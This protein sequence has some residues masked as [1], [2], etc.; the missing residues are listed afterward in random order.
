MQKTGTIKT[1]TEIPDKLMTLDQSRILLRN[2][3]GPSWRTVSIKEFYQAVE[4]VALEILS[5][6]IREND[7][8][9]IYSDNCCQ[10]II[11]DFAI[12][13]CGAITVP[14]YPT[15]PSDQIQFILQN[16]GVRGIFLSHQKE[17][18]K[19]RSLQS[20]LPKLVWIVA[21]EEM[22]SLPDHCWNMEQ[23]MEEGR[24]RRSELYEELQR[25]KS[26]IQPDHIASIIYTSGTT[27]IPKGVMLS[28]GNFI[29]NIEATVDL[30]KFGSQDVGLSFLPL[31][32]VFERYA[33]YKYLYHGASIA[34]SSVDRILKHCAEV[35]PTVTA[36][37]PRIFEI[38]QEKILSRLHSSS[39][40]KKTLFRWGMAIGRKRGDILLSG[41][42]P[43]WLLQMLFFLAKNIVFR[44]LHKNLGKRFRFFISGGGPLL[45]EIG[46][47]FY[48]MGVTICEGYGLT[49]TS[50]VVAVN[51]PQDVRFGTVGKI[52]EGVEVKIAE[53]GEILVQGPNVMKGYYKNEIATRETF[54]D[55][56]LCTGDTGELTDGYLIIKERKKDIIVT[57]SG[58]NIS[59][60]RIENFL[61]RSSFINNAVV[62]GDAMD[63]IS[64]LIVPNFEVL[65]EKTDHL[66]I[67]A[68]KESDLI[69]NEKIIDLYRKE[70][71]AS[72][73]SL[74][75]YE[76]VRKFALM[77]KEFTIESGEMTP[78]MK[79]KRR[80]VFDRYHDLIES[81]YPKTR[82][83]QERNP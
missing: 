39:A 24:Q 44:Q 51:T 76:K 65:K 2:C 64:A 55:G 35:H 8:V 17:F 27:G 7:R 34:F 48:A 13:M 45:P 41:K 31:S 73:R 61:K 68:L 5:L 67:S 71:F 33:D 14:V 4:D 37:V 82:D 46:K 56:W 32:H 19:I 69:K 40:V 75:S 62:F 72:T 42:K 21:F 29:S 22:E 9:A 74:A 10:W 54:R 80:V 12:L 52:V 78:T 50:P 1:L 57:S 60:Q 36:S 18:R 58:K 81:M 47:F 79:I 28:Q 59:P 25:R 11:A 43:S 53:D 83:R 16:S 66:D 3:E 49:E 20:S 77:D 70:I 23:F 26:S 63:Y 15:L 30:V 6:G 38:M